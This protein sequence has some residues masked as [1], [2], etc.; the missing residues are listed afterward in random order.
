MVTMYAGDK[1]VEI[2]YVSGGTYQFDNIAGIGYRPDKLLIIWNDYTMK[3]VDN[4]ADVYKH[5]AC[6]GRFDIDVE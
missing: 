2:T 6:P 1:Q 4:P 5:I 3:Q